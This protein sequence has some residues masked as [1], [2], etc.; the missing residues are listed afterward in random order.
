M[1]T[2]KKWKQEPLFNDVD[3]SKIQS[4]NDDYQFVFVDGNQ[5]NPARKVIIDRDGEI[6][7]CSIGIQHPTK[8]PVILN[9]GLTSRND[10]GTFIPRGN[11]LMICYTYMNAQE[12]ESNPSPV[13]VVDSI[14]YQ[15][16]GHY[17]KDGEI[18][19]YPISG[20][21][22]VYTQ[23]KVGCIDSVSI[24]VFIDGNDIKRVNV[25]IADAEY[26]ESIIPPSAYRL[27]SSQIIREGA[28]EH[29]IIISSSRSPIEVSHENDLAA[30]GDAVAVVDGITFIGNATK[31]IG[32]PYKPEK[33]W[34]ITLS[35]K[36]KYN[37]IN[38]WLRLDLLDEA[39]IKPVGEQIFTGLDW[40]TDDKSKFRLMD[41]DLIT[42]LECYHY[43]LD[44]QLKMHRE[45]FVGG[46]ATRA[47]TTLFFPGAPSP[48]ILD[49]YA[50]MYGA[51]GN[52]Y[53]LEMVAGTTKGTIHCKYDLALEI[54]DKIILRTYLGVYH[55]TVIVKEAVGTN[56]LSIEHSVSDYKHTI[57]ITP[58]STDGVLES[59]AEDIYQM[60]VFNSEDVSGKL[61]EIISEVYTES[62][63][64]FE[65]SHKVVAQ[66]NDF[67][68]LETLAVESG[69]KTIIY[70]AYKSSSDMFVSRAYDVA[71]AINRLVGSKIYAI[72]NIGGTAHAIPSPEVF[73]SGGTGEA[74]VNPSDTIQTRMHCFVRIPQIYSFQ[75]KTIYLVKF[76][77]KPT[78]IECPITE[79]DIEQGQSGIT[80]N[81]F[82]EQKL[83][84]NPLYG[85]G[86]LAATRE[87]QGAPI[88]DNYEKKNVANI[89]F[90]GADT[91]GSTTTNKTNNQMDEYCRYNDKQA[92]YPW[93]YHKKG[94]VGQYYH[95][96]KSGTTFPREGYLYCTI[97]PPS[98]KIIDVYIAMARIDSGNNIVRKDLIGLGFCKTQNITR[99][100][101]Y[102]FDKSGSK[103]TQPITWINLSELGDEYTVL[104]SWR[105]IT[106]Q[107]ER[108]EV[109][110]AVS[111]GENYYFGSET[112][113]ATMDETK[114]I[115]LFYAGNYEGNP[116]CLAALCKD[117]FI[118]NEWQA[119]N[120]LK[121]LSFYPTEGIGVYD[122]FRENT[123]DTISVVNKNTDIQVINFNQDNLPGRIQ[124]GA[125]GAMP[126]L[127]EYKINEAIVALVPLKSFQ[128]TDEHN[129]LLVFTPNNT[130]I[131]A[132]LGN[133]ARSCT[134][135]RQLSGIGLVN[136]DAVCVMRTG[137]AWLSGDGI[138]LMSQG[139][140]RNISRGRIK[141]DGITTIIYD[142]KRNWVWARGSGTTL[143]Y[144]ADEDVWWKYA[145]SV[146]PDGFL[147][148]IDEEY[149]WICYADDATI[150]IDSERPHTETH[151]TLIK[152]RAIPL[153]KRI[154][155]VK[156]LGALGS[157][158]YNLKMKL[159]SNKIASGSQETQEIS[160]TMNE[161]ISLPNT[162]ADY[163]Q[164]TISKANDVAAVEIEDG[165]RQWQTNTKDI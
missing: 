160:A 88:Q 135:S 148:T 87:I 78:E 12:E 68:E 70:L 159:Y 65:K 67:S 140:T 127:N 139:G 17:T 48:Y 93:A 16:K 85:E 55:A 50:K 90:D 86:V 102:V 162:S 28:Q 133:S 23:D 9:V 57:T 34:A 53:S 156:L 51:I 120:L 63:D 3:V 108:I 5:N 27:I 52:S 113:E 38:R 44:A 163:A 146:H 149:G 111:D 110:L 125:Y 37:Y 11:V 6:K 56:S 62:N 118:E 76:A 105:I 31:G 10:E 150:Y 89:Y 72:A 91:L 25:Y 18:Y 33:V 119:L 126:D 74:P 7:P 134:M 136:K 46:Y 123:D 164:L 81:E 49:V 104:L 98:T 154:N 143:V 121:F 157:K 116:S 59:T 79:M 19:Y 22:Y 77:D 40:K 24:K 61:Y 73:L 153:L 107:S 165:A 32:L 145:G 45:I 122:E 4:A 39:G 60:L 130:Y 29:N 128:P 144:Q 95:N 131:F 92:E 20:G 83:I 36:N 124:W 15:A 138:M 106:E 147:G 114:E 152:T 129:T 94:A 14:Q 142:S 115:A 8:K 100:C 80:I 82:Y 117:V 71:D 99:L 2:E 41:S 109:S 97:S 26:V 58:A 13:L 112:I 75:E 161:K 42:P 132:L 1:A 103:K 96:V 43:P 64:E 30:S 35:N 137:V 47:K 84:K 141:T 54:H 158:S 101:I 21:T 155:R 69:D 66:E 151:K